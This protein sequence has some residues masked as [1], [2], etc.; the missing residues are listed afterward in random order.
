MYQVKTDKEIA[1][2]IAMYWAAYSSTVINNGKGDIRMTAVI[3]ALF[4]VCD[5][6]ITYPDHHKQ[7]SITQNP[8]Y[9]DLEQFRERYTKDPHAN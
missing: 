7:E 1:E 6:P 8:V 9:I 2:A 3:A 5:I 4:W